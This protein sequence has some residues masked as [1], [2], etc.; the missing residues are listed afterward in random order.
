VKKV[1][2]FFVIF[3]DNLK[4][5]K[6]G[7]VEKTLGADEK[8]VSKF[9]IHPIV[10][11]EYILFIWLIFPIYGLIKL[12]FV[13]Y[14]LTNKRVVTK[15]G[16]ISRDTE[17]MRLSKAET[18]EVKQGIIGR[19]FGYGNVIVTGTGISNV[20]FSYVSKPLQVKRDID[21]QLS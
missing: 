18:V 5:F 19:I 2:I 15:A 12:F 14:T 21:S 6:M 3:K 20:V 1:L 13:E 7:Y 16:I 11:L 17:E 9:K 10:Y 8:I 4:I